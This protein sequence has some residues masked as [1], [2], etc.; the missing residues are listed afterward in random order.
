MNFI[1]N[2]IIDH[3]FIIIGCIGIG[4]YFHSLELGFS[5][6]FIIAGIIPMIVD[7]VVEKLKK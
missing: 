2:R 1:I 4:H 7:C 5:C 6:Y 3:S